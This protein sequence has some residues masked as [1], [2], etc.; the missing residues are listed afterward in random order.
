MLRQ[1]L[2]RPSRCAVTVLWA[3]A[4]ATAA[5]AT[6]TTGQALETGV[7]RIEVLVDGRALVEHPARGTIYVEALR[8]REYAIRLTNLVD[9][10]IA[11]ALAVDGL[12]SIDA[13][14]T[15]ASEASK[16]VLRPHETTTISGWQVSSADARRFF[17]TTEEQSYASWLGRDANLGVIEAV[18]YREREPRRIL[19]QWLG[20]SSKAAPSPSGR[21]LPS[22]ETGAPPVEEADAGGLAATGIGRRIDHRVRRVSLDLESQPAARLRLRYEYREQ[23]VHLGVLPSL[24]EEKSLARR[25]NARG[26][27]DFSFAPDPFSR[28]R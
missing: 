26:F 20:G 25:E 11:V 14:T 21:H 1:S 22:D 27:S 7:C 9:R 16:W 19:R 3:I 10:R 6:A 12:N 17:F 8:G 18:V 5:L 28:K 2:N 13:K 15:S 23:L 4:A 24:E